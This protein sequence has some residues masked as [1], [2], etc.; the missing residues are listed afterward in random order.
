M[1]HLFLIRTALALAL[2]LAFPAL[3]AQKDVKDQV[4]TAINQGNAAALSKYMVANVDMSLP[5]ASDYYSKAQAEQILRKFFDEHQPKSLNIAHE[6]TNRSGDCYYIGDLATGKGD[7]RVTFFLKK[8]SDGY[9]VKQLRIE[10]GK[11]ER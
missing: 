4:V 10:T 5:N 1:R 11:S 2:L 7:F 8:G 3:H 6:G 9:Q